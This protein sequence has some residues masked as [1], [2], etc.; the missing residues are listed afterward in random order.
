MYIFVFF[1]M[2]RRPPRSTRTDTLFPYTTL[3]R[4]A[5]GDAPLPVVDADQ[6]FDF[7]GFDEDGVHVKGREWGMGNGASV[8]PQGSRDP[9]V[10]QASNPST[11]TNRD[12]SAAFSSIFP[13]LPL[14]LNDRRR[15][16]LPP[17]QSM[18]TGAVSLRGSASHHPAPPHPRP[19][20]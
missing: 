4:S 12:H 15:P 16:H 6:G 8:P 19:R 3:F 17:R 20:C 9:S 2:I 18:Y 1:L 7:E 14:P 10:H 5:A 13:L 11:A